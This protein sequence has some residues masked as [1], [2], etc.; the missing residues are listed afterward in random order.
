MV[1]ALSISLLATVPLRADGS[2]DP[3]AVSEQNGKYLDKDGNPT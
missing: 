2:G 1:L 3:T